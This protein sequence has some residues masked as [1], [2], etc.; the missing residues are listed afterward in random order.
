MPVR[1]CRKKL[2]YQCEFGIDFIGI[3]RDKEGVKDKLD[4]FKATDYINF[5][6]FYLK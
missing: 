3:L 6:N 1:F 5:T 4:K 2:L